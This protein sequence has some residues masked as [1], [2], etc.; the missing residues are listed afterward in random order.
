MAMN[1]REAEAMVAACREAG[2]K[3]G[4]SYYRRYFPQIEAALEVVESG[5]IGEVGLIRSYNSGYGPGP[6]TGGWRYVPEIGGGGALMDVG[7]HRIDLVVL[8]GGKL[9]AATGFAETRRRGWEVDDTATALATFESGAH[10]IVT[11]DWCSE[12]SVDLFE[13]Y[14]TEGSIT[15]PN[16]S[17]PTINVCG[18]DG[19]RTIEVTPLSA[20]D[21]DLHLLDHFVRWIRGEGEC[22][23]TG[24]EGAVTTRIMDAAYANTAGRARPPRD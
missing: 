7:S 8:L 19:E 17:G 1:A 14:G 24:E 20:E 5:Q 10:G 23:C 21:R 18:R 16:L 6:E 12:S 9:V 4:V 2:V 15:I 22:R 13:I 3:L 11:V